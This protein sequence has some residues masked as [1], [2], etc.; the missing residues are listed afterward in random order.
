MTQKDKQ[1]VRKNKGKSKIIEMTNG[2]YNDLL[3][4]PDRKKT[5]RR[6]KI[7]T[8]KADSIKTTK[9]RY[10]ITRTGDVSLQMFENIT[11]A[12][13]VIRFLARK[14][15]NIKISTYTI[16][17]N[18]LKKHAVPHLGHIPMRYITTAHINTALLNEHELKPST[19]RLLRTVLSI[20]F[21]SACR[22]E[23]IADNPVR[24]SDRILGG[25]SKVDLLLPTEEEMNLLLTILK[26][27]HYLL[28][29][30]VKATIHS[31]LRKGEL[32]GLKWTSLNIEQNILQIRT[33][34]N[35]YGT[36]ISLKTLS[37]IRDVHINEAVM[38][39]ILSLPR[40][41]EYVFPVSAHHYR[42]LKRYFVKM[43]FHERM[44][45]HDLRHYHATLLMRKG[46]NIKIISK[47]LGHKDVQ[48]TL[49]IYTHHDP[50]MDRQ[51][52]NLLND[53]HII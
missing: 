13:Y 23:L 42:L 15:D 39:T 22:E 44:T 5:E 34:K 8:A 26:K 50:E 21:N 43:G 36:D 47:R 17:E 38:Q 11:F 10:K 2:K 52:A 24:Y 31:G 6:S 40:V 20:V 25:Q 33:Q 19:R 7:V 9:E 16:Y 48:T 51:V 1:K 32:Q 45:F 37:S 3:V 30:L 4:F 53:T 46:V 41:S 28:Y 49:N 29:V 12:E 27:E 18:I 14:Q 35:S